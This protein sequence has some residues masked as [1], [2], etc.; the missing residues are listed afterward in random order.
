M[1]PSIGTGLALAVVESYFF[2]VEESVLH[3]AA[4]DLLQVRSVYK[5]EATPA[6]WF[7]LLQTTTTQLQIQ[8]HRL[9]QLLH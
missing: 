8:L 5:V 3:H 6:T 2:I 7:T 4:V 1:N 9:L